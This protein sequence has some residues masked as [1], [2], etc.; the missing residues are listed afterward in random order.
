MGIKKIGKYIL[1]F[2]RYVFELI[3]EYDGDIAVKGK[4]NF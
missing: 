1:E 3:Q 2:F 4:N